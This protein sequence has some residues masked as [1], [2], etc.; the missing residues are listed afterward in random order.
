VQIRRII[1]LYLSLI[2]LWYLLRIQVVIIKTVSFRHF[3]YSGTIKSRTTLSWNDE[4]IS[5]FDCLFFFIYRAWNYTYNTVINSYS[6]MYT[7]RTVFQTLSFYS[8]KIILCILL[9]FNQ[10]TRLHFFFTFTQYTLIINM[11]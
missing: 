5:N 9:K 11:W 10:L 4:T 6:H 7:F 8:Y 3:V 2:Y 1:S